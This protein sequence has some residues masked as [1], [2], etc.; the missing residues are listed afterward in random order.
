MRAAHVDQDISGSCT[1]LNWEN[2][3][4]AQEMANCDENNECLWDDVDE[5]ELV[6]AMLE[7]ESGL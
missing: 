3:Q 5:S 2:P 1:F 4:R 6:G 7:T